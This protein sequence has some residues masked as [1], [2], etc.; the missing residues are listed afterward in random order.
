MPRNPQNNISSNKNNENIDM[1]KD[2]NIDKIEGNNNININI[3]EKVNNKNKKFEQKKILP[4]VKIQLSIIYSTSIYS[5]FLISFGLFILSC[6]CAWS[7]YG[8]TTLPSSFLFIG[9]FEYILGIYDFYQGN[10]LLFIQNI[11]FGIRYINFFLNYFEINGLKRTKILFSNMQGVI[12]FIMFA[13]VSIFSL[14]IKGRGILYFIDYFLLLI[15]TAF[16]IL[17]GYAGDY[18]IIIKISGYILFITSISFWI[19]GIFLVINDISQTKYFK[20]VEPRI[21]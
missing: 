18:N 7:E 6:N 20:F 17:S 16:F 14:K 13:F 12:D 3:K 21:K 9:I 10:N 11:I 19:T 2:I 1:N 15:S 5:Y 4:E 8:S